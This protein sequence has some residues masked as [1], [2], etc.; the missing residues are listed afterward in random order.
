MAIV[1]QCCS[2]GW[3]G[4]QASLERKC[5]MDT[6][7]MDP[8]LSTDVLA[9]TAAPQ[10]TQRPASRRLLTFYT[11]ASFGSWAALITPIA[12]TMALR[13]QQIDPAG[14]AA[15]LGLV[16]GAGAFFPVVIGPVIGLLSDRTTSRL[17]MCRPW[18]IGGAI[19]GFLG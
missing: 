16:L 19:G 2:R 5:F 6:T 4:L 7:Q 3:H 12:V 17:V 15:S 8:A 10:H 11:L 13:V 1:Q 14:K 9:V 18:I